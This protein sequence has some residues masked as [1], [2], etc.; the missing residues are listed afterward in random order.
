MLKQRLELLNGINY[1]RSLKG[2]DDGALQSVIAFFGHC[3]SANF[4]KITTFRKLDLLPP[5]GKT[6]SLRPGRLRSETSS[7]R[8]AQQLGFLP[9]PF[10]LKTEEDPASET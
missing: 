10:C 2:S 4:S 6:G 1:G 3:P 8:G 7:T 9:S 5:S